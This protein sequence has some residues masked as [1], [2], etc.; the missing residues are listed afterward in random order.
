M[1]VLTSS[2]LSSLRLASAMLVFAVTAAF[3]AEQLPEKPQRFFNDYTGAVDRDVGDG[4]NE[5]LA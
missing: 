2:W 3:A 1:S 5:R 4:L